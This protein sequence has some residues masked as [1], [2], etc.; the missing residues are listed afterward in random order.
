[1]FA[2]QCGRSRLEVS[3]EVQSLAYPGNGRVYRNNQQ[4]NWT[5]TLHNSTSRIRIIFSSFATEESYD[6]LT[7]SCEL[8]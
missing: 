5:L 7:V 1:M 3:D 4:C 6:F 2:G 8:V